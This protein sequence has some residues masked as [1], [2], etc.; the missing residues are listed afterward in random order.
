MLQHRKHFKMRTL[1]GCKMVAYKTLAT[2]T[3]HMAEVMQ[4]PLEGGRVLSLCSSLKDTSPKGAEIWI[5]SLTSQP[6]EH[7]DC[8]MQAGP[9]AKATDNYSGEGNESFSSG[10]EASDDSTH[11]HDLEEDDFDLGKAKKQWQLTVGTT[12]MKKQQSFRQKDVVL[13]P[14]LTVSQEA[15]DSE[16]DP[17]QHVPRMEEDLNL[18]NVT[19]EYP[20]D[21][22][23]DMED[24]DS[25]LSTPKSRLWQYIEHLS[26]STLETETGSTHSAQ[27]LKEPPSPTNVRKK[28]WAPGGHLD[29]SF[30]DSVAHS[31]P[32]PRS[33]RHSLRTARRQRPHRDAAGQ[34]AH[35]QGRVSHQP[36]TPSEGKQADHR[37]QSTSL[38]RGSRRGR[39][40]SCP[41][42]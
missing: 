38:R 4:R 6:I 18:V 24:D 28:M 42:A 36:L 25:T 5:F 41:T 19:L 40:T 12:F 9:K 2:G 22:G 11:G 30:A 23:P 13:P 26:Q 1:V 20:S 37:G 35:Q 32:S 29:D 27:S 21:S 8:A 14:R 31:T 33:S 10:Q 39:R 3:I 16:Q 15:Q 34:Q 7:E 17:V